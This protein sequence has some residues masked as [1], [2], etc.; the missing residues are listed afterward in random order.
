MKGNFSQNKRF[1]NPINSIFVDEI[2][3]SLNTDLQQDY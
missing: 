2:N 1:F 3:Y